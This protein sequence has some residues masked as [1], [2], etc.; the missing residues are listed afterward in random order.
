[1][2]QE[3][4]LG[5]ADLA[6]ALRGLRWEKLLHL[7]ERCRKKESGKEQQRTGPS[8]PSIPCRQISNFPVGL[9]ELRSFQDH[10]KK[11]WTPHPLERSF[12]PG[13]AFPGGRSSVR[14]V[15]FSSHG[16]EI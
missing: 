10:S 4:C 16:I 6:P 8:R 13:L 3:F 7:A 15:E 5:F 14:V 1:M 11:P 9:E 12:L 2:G